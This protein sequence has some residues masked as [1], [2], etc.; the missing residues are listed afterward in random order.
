MYCFLADVRVIKYLM[1]T[2][3]FFGL[4]FASLTSQEM[5]PI[6][7]FFIWPFANFLQNKNKVIRISPLPCSKPITFEKPLS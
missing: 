5:N 7:L 6:N 4:G 2:D 3:R 1:I